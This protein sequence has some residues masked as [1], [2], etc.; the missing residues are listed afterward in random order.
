MGNIFNEDF[1]DFLAALHVCGVR[2]V[3]VGGYSVILHG[4]SRTTGDLDIWV[5]KSAD[6]YA[7]LTQAFQHFGMPTFDMT[8]ENFL[9]RPDFDV[10]TF[11]RPPVAIDIITTL[12]G[13]NFADAH[14]QAS[15]TVVEGLTVRLIH[16]QHLLQAK[17]AAGRPRDHNDL[18]N[19]QRS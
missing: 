3:L 8:V 11:G 7:L 4:Y 17:R 2:Y 14:A 12:K 15:D 6:N 9:H 10:F 16:Y 1:R 5:E 13:L 19:L 18:D